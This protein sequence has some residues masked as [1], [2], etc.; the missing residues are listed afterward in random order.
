MTRAIMNERP[1]TLMVTP[2]EFWSPRRWRRY[3]LGWESKGAWLIAEID[4]RI[5]GMLSVHRGERAT[6]KHTAEF[7]VTVA[8]E[9]RGIGVGR[10]LMEA[11]EQWARE[12]GIV[13]ITLRV[14]THN[15]R[16]RALYERMGYEREGVERRQVRFADG[17]EVDTML[18]AKFLV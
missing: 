10:A 11:M 3:R 1:R 8:A 14:F 18:M 13:K 17:E 16:A 5:A 9:A 12:H 7:G 15:D 4:G 6:V 2:E